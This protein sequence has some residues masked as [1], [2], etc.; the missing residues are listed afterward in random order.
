MTLAASVEAD[1]VHG[2]WKLGAG[3]FAAI[4][5]H[6][7]LDAMPLSILATDQLPVTRFK[8]FVNG[9]FA[10]LCPVGVAFFFGA[11]KQFPLHQ[12]V[13]VGCGLAFSAGVFLCISLSDLLPELEFHAHDRVALSVALIAGIALAYAI[14]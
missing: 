7:P 10:A 8:Q 5:L 1:A 14:V 13:I 6:R 3:T 9:S 4:F 12:S 2:A 11:I